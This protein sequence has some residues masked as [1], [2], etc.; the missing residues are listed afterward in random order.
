M[1]TADPKPR[2]AVTPMVSEATYTGE[3]RTFTFT[4]VPEGID[5]ASFSV[6]YH[7]RGEYVDALAGEPTKVGRYQVYVRRDEDA[8]NAGYAAYAAWFDF[9]IVRGEQD[10]PSAPMLDTRDE[11][12]ITLK[13]MTTP[14]GYGEVQYGYV[15]S[16]TAED[17]NNWQTSSTFEGLSAGTAYTFFARYAA[18]DNY[19][20]S[21]ASDGTT[22]ATLP[23]APEASNATIDYEDE[24]LSVPATCEVA[25]DAAFGEASLL[26]V[27]TEEGG[28]SY[29]E[30][31]EVIPANGE[32]ALTLYVRF[33]AHDNIP[34][35][36]SIKVTVPPRP[37]TPSGLAVTME[38]DADMSDG[39]ISGLDEMAGY[40]YRAEGD[41]T[42]STVTQ[43]SVAIEDLA[44][45]TYEI[46]VAA[47]EG[48]SF[49]SAA[50]SVTV[51]TATYGLSAQPVTFGAVAFGY[52]QPEWCDVIV[53]NTGNSAVTI[54]SA[55]LDQTASQA[56]ELTSTLSGA[57]I[58]SEE[59][60]T[61]SDLLRPKAG[62]AEGTYNGTVT[63]TAKAVD[64]RYADP[65][66]CSF[67]ASFTVKQSGTNLGASTYNGDTATASF[68]YG[69]T[70]TVKG[71]AKPTGTAATNAL[72]EPAEGQVALYHGETQISDAAPV[73]EGGSF[74]LSYDTAGKLVPVG[75]Q[76]ELEVR[77]VGTADMASAEQVVKV[78][79]GPKKLAADIAADEGVLDADD[80]VTKVY[81]GTMK[82]PDGL[83]IEL[84]GVLAPDGT[85]DEVSA[86]PEGGYAYDSADV[87]G[88]TKVTAGG[89]ALSGDDAPFYTL[90]G[91]DPTV[92]AAIVPRSIV[93]AVV[94]LGGQLV[95]DG[96]EQTQTIVKVTVG[97]LDATKSVVVSGNT[98]TDAGAYTMTLTG[99][100]NFTGEK[101]VRFTVAQSGSE[102]G[103]AFTYNGDEKTSSFTY[104]DTVTVKGTVGPTGEA[105]T[106][107]LAE[108]AEDQVALYYED[109]QISGAA[110]VEDGGSFELDCATTDR[111]V[112]VG[113]QIELEVRYVGT[114]DM[115]DAAATVTIDLAKAT[116]TPSV[117]G[118]VSKAYDGT[119]DVTGAAES[120]LAIVLEGAEGDD[121]PT[122]SASFSFESADA[123][124][125][126]AVN[127][128]DI[129]LDEDSERWYVLS[130]SELTLAG[131]G[132]IT[133]SAPTMTLPGEQELPAGATVGDLEAPTFTDVG[134]K[135]LEGALTW[136]A[137]EEC[138]QRLSEGDAL[139]SGERTL[140]WRF[141]P[142]DKNYSVATG[143]LSVSV[144]APVPP[145]SSR[146]TYPTEV[147]TV[148]DGTAT[149]SPS[150]P[151]KGSIV[152]VTPEPGE[153]NQVAS[154][155]ATDAS[156]AP[157][158]VADNGDGTWS[159]EQPSS[160]VTV[161]V[162]FA[163][164]GGALCPSAGFPDVD[165]SQWYHG[166][167]DWALSSGAMY[168]YASGLFGP[169]DPLTREQAACVVYNLLG[170]GDASAPAAPQA[171]VAQG[172]WY[173]AA[174]NW[175]VAHGVM[176]GYG[177]S[178]VFGVGD[179]LTREQFAAVLANVCDADLA[180]ADPSALA[181]FGDASEVS[182][183]A[184]G[185]MTWAVEAGVIN[186]V[187][188]V[189]GG[190]ELQPGREISRA[191]MAA[192]MMNAV[193]S[194]VLGL[195]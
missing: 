144:S 69:D 107:A 70:I 14:T 53:K 60:K 178:D 31:S 180:A 147:V 188:T 40:E 37:A 93:D 172:Q 48:V 100:G 138:T 177:G 8:G 33:A 68:T 92:P 73:S 82:A 43:G 38:S 153:G 116:L 3:P 47:A 173:S 139:G 142:T 130:K 85:P 151:H 161:T 158:E 118:S 11:G 19:E 66:S 36:E 54:M 86:K 169:D 129:V 192:M 152:T 150:R 28:A 156:G 67:K 148:G 18:N 128:T 108:P 79:L 103:G 154:V 104:G 162:T 89:L 22:I 165:R 115:A 84:E 99:K 1:K 163:C 191:E 132:T 176:N 29:V 168:G 183:W 179:P 25:A 71:T 133:P 49:A 101:K 114:D 5:P 35:S 24:Q 88:A 111:A 59:T 155:E 167:V 57:T 26:K 91:A 184:K 7:E 74:E 194:G 72:A 2:I 185:V 81:D 146:P 171:D 64:T 78:E 90:D 131:V 83:S 76:I 135:P 119:T 63:L 10:K 13:T 98:A 75:E 6:T 77:Y 42:W 45:D 23:E 127:A 65:V 145:T 20:E 157:V 126:I 160:T 102:V 122:A 32:G 137:D 166:A 30:L 195:G 124:E 17:V 50:A 87:E 123:G 51:E 27:V 170:A 113:E 187:D 56:F 112:P 95:Y 109:T 46:R 34:A 41:E 44:D 94:V 9:E 141:E 15:T 121:A 120:T 97:G 61:L 106:N 21:L 125:G 16:G 12:S 55:K 140:W 193:E 52:E 105:A 190:R 164:D 189:G 182:D 186:G 117:T 80:R 39:V 134:G 149:V 159:F 62:L 136:Y 175:A 58:G 96:S 110:E 174:V 143:S 4:T 181:A